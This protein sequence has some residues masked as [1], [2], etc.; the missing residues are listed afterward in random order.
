MCNGLFFR[1]PTQSYVTVA[2]LDL[3][4]FPCFLSPCDN[5]CTV[6]SVSPYASNAEVPYSQAPEVIESSTQGGFDWR[7]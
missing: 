1:L 3:N 2:A 5:F 4:L 7:V 6:S